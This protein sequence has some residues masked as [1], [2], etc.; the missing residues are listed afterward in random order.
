ML[1]LPF[2]MATVIGAFAPLPSR[3]VFEHAKRLVVGARPSDTLAVGS[4]A[5]SRA[6]DA[7]CGC[8]PES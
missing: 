5:T 3:R 4:S 7:A 6:A 2:A 8:R 1:T